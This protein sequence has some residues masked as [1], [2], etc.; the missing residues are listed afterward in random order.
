MA[1]KKK[2]EKKTFG[3]FSELRKENEQ[4]KELNSCSWFG[5]IL[6]VVLFF[7]FFLKALSSVGALCVI[8]WIVTAI[9]GVCFLLGGFYPLALK[10]LMKLMQKVG[11]FLGKYIMRVLMLPIYLVMMIPALFLGRGTAKK[12]EFVS[13]KDACD[14]KPEYIPYKENEYKK[15]STGFL[16]T[17]NN[18]MFFLAKN[19]LLFLLPIVIILVIV[20]LVFFFISANS[21]F[22][23]IYALF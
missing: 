1:G 8:Y 19:K 13:W 14:F 11:N 20:G 21:V 6:G 12:Y 22:T 7:V 2:K 15:G 17:L 10:P 3:S 5:L 18:L 4:K 16:G 23:F 9:G